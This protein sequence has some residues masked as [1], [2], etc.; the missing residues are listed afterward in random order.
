MVALLVVPFVSNRGERAPSRRPV[1]VL[2]VIVIY[3]LV[4]S[5]DVRR[6]D[7]PLVAP[8]DRL[9]RRSDLGGWVRRAPPVQLLG[10]TVFQNKNCRNCHALN[11]VGGRRDRI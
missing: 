5:A 8:D 11:G 4:G 2:S 7:G 10:A 6:G 3:H 9:E 1:A